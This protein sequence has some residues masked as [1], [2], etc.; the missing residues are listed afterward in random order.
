MTPELAAITVAAYAYTV[1]AL[2]YW[3]AGR[4]G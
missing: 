3:R 1:L 4:K 2:L